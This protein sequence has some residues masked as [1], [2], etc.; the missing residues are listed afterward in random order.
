[1]N[2]TGNHRDRHTTDYTAILIGFA[3]VL[4]LELLLHRFLASSPFLRQLYLSNDKRNSLTMMVDNLG[5]A[6][7]LGLVN[8]WVGHQWGTRKLGLVAV[9]LTVGV[10]SSQ[11]LYQLFF[12]HEDLWWWPPQVG[13]TIFWLG[14]ALTIVS[15]FTYEGSLLRVWHSRKRTQISAIGRR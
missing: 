3:V 12:R 9:L 13:E 1:M 2:R 7:I 8:G 10:V 6:A 11:G 5:P 15:L 14:F 4:C